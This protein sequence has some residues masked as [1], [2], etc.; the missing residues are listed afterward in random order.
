MSGQSPQWQNDSITPIISASFFSSLFTCRTS[1][2]TTIASLTSLRPTGNSIISSRF[3][4]RVKLNPRDQL[5]L[6]PTLS[7]VF[8]IQSSCSLNSSPP[9]PLCTSVVPSANNPRVHR[10]RNGSSPPQP[11]TSRANS[12][13]KTQPLRKDNRTQQPNELNVNR[14]ESNTQNV[15]TPLRT[16]TKDVDLMR[17][18]EEGK[19]GE[20]L[21]FMGRGV[22]ADYGVFCVLLESCDG[23]KSLE[24]GRKVHEFLRQSPFRGDI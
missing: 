17:L 4:S 14:N 13:Y 9:K 8:K 21:E 19:V 16:N 2:T 3:K 5:F 24:V 7:S 23:L 6:N 10:R 15:S 11:T 1:L 22:S 12:Q 20:A 18:C